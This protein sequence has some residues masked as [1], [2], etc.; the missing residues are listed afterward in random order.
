[1]PQPPSPGAVHRTALF[2]RSGPYD[3]KLTWERRGRDRP[4][5]C[6]GPR[7]TGT[8]RRAEQRRFTY[9]TARA[10]WRWTISAWQWKQRGAPARL[11]PA[12]HASLERERRR[13]IGCAAGPAGNETS[14]LRHRDNA[15]GKDRKRVTRA[16]VQVG[17]LAKRTLRRGSQ[18]IVQWRHSRR[19]FRLSTRVPLLRD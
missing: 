3:P 9:A 18:L 1:M 5:R 11:R 2:K 15:C 8:W 13:E 6:N 14:R 4:G 10:A 7:W 16:G 19:R 12:S 17:E